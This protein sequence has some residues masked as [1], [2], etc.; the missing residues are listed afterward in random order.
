MPKTIGNDPAFPNDLLDHRVGTM[1]TGGLTKRELFVVLIAQGLAKNFYE[2]DA[3][4]K[5]EEGL[6]SES[7]RKIAAERL[8][9]DACYIADHLI[10]NLN[11]TG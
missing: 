2:L 7:A 5:D 4:I 6:E 1:A 8:T 10:E 3:I 11:A 9:R